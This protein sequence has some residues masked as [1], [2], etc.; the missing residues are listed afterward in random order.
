MTITGFDNLQSI[1]EIDDDDIE[2]M[3]SFGRHSL[4]EII[5]TNANLFDYLFYQKDFLN[6]KIIPGHK[7]AIKKL[8]NV[9]H[10]KGVDYFLKPLKRL[11][12]QITE[13][14]KAKTRKIYDQSDD[15][16]IIENIIRS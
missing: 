3:E 8:K 9:I 10:E 13:V 2:E 5:P 1:G 6:Y 16:K 12:P 15:K 11:L 7:K 4:R 14:N